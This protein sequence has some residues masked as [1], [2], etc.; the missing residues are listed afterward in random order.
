MTNSIAEH[1]EQVK[2]LT[3]NALMDSQEGLDEFR[4]IFMQSSDCFDEGKNVDGMSRLNDAISHLAEFAK[5]CATV[6]EV[7]NTNLNED[8]TNELTQKCESFQSLLDQIVKESEAQNYMEVSDILR[9]DLTDL[10]TSYSML[11][12]RL[13][14]ELN[15]S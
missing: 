4:R 7:C 13:A 11:F 15:D 8:S 2:S 3:I 9:F 14:N 10:M 5:F 1:N 12:P 6:Q